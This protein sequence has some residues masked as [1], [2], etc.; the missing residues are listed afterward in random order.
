MFM[1]ESQAVFPLIAD[2]SFLSPGYFP[3]TYMTISTAAYYKE[4]PHRSPESFLCAAV[5]SVVLCSVNFC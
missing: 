5:S 1:C 2:D 3:H 4:T